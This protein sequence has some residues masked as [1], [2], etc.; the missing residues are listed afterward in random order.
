MAFLSSPPTL[1]ISPSPTPG[2]SV[3]TVGYQIQF[4]AF[5]RAAD[6]PYLETV[7]LVGDDTGVLGDPATAAPDDNIALI[8]VSTIR[9]SMNLGPVAFVVRNHTRTI[10]T[11]SLDEDRAPVP[12]PDEIRAVVA[13]TPQSPRADTQ[14]SNL[15]TLTIGPQTKVPDVAE[16]V[17]DRAAA[18]VTA[19][20]L[21]PRF[22]MQP[23]MAPRF[24]VD[25][26]PRAATVVENGTTVFMTLGSG[27]PDP[28]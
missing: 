19:A 28:V 21:E 22:R 20:G 8:N 5:D 23:G 1:T 3:V 24:V 15:V 18:A 25:Q 10:P 12:N 16:L 14:Q 27:V 7:T 26:T 9:A 13:L 11:T 6:Q 17:R 4:D 2:Q